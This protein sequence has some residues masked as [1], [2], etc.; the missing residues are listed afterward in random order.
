VT[1]MAHTELRSGDQILHF[2]GER[3][4]LASSDNPSHDKPRWTEIAI[5]RTDEGKYVVSKIGK[6]R[7]IHATLDC[8]ALVHNEDELE[9]VNASSPKFFR[10]RECWRRGVINKQGYLEADHATAV[11]ADLPQ[12]AVGAC[13]TRDRTLGLWS[14]TWLAQTA[15]E[16]AC[17][18]DEDLDRAYLNFDI[19]SLGRRPR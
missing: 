13:Y 6:S 14:L 11:M 15:L 9:L 12:G 4:S 19:G 3:L 1:I 17:D 2:E 5:Y 8:I 7:V 16:D 10:C 18:V